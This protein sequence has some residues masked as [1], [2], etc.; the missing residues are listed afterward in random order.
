MVAVKAIGEV[1]AG[2]LSRRFQTSDWPVERAA[3]ASPCRGTF[4][5]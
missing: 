5:P 4:N 2:A 3:L 1:R